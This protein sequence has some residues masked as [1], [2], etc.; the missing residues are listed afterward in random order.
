[1]DAN[2]PV[3]DPE[4]TWR[5]AESCGYCELLCGTRSGNC[6]HQR[7]FG[8]NN[9]PYKTVFAPIDKKATFSCLGWRK[10]A[11]AWIVSGSFQDLDHCYYWQANLWQRSGVTKPIAFSNAQV[12]IT[13]AKYYISSGRCVQ[14]RWLQQQESDDGRVE[15]IPDSL[16]TAFKT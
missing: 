2:A 8:L 3:L 1:M 9:K 15:K 4:E 14:A 13:V 16:I 11:S 12:K 6:L 5:P 7:A 10:L